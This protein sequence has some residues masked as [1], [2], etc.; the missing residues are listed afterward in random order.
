MWYREAQT[1]PKQHSWEAF[2]I[3][4]IFFSLFF[5]VWFSCLLARNTNHGK[6]RTI[7]SSLLAYRTVVCSVHIFICFDHENLH[8]LIENPPKCDHRHCANNFSRNIPIFPILHTLQNCLNMQ[9]SFRL[10][11]L[12]S[13]FKYTV[14]EVYWSWIEILMFQKNLLREKL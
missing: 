13:K 7:F 3:V 12:V 10:Q 5:F 1:I 6:S 2:M 9:L 8:Q 4:F 11:I 14:A